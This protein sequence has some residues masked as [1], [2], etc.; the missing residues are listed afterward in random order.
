MENGDSSAVEP[1]DSA[2]PAS[3]LGPDFAAALADKNFGRITELLDPQVDFR[4]LTPRRA[5]EASSATEVVSAVLAQWFEESD[6]IDEL[7][8]VEGVAFADRQRVG[9]RF[10]GHNDD[11]PFTVE[12]QA[13][14]TEQEGRIAWMRVLC[15]GFRPG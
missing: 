12:Q 9:Y 14:F 5:W 2:G 6:H 8:E 7:L 4:G 15:S 3:S 10:R 11:G 1:P 13:Y